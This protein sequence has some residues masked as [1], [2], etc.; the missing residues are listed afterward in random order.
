MKKLFLIAL[1]F[2]MAA[3]MMNCNSK[4]RE[5]SDSSDGVMSGSVVDSV[6]LEWTGYKTTDKAPVSGVF[7]QINVEGINNNGTTPEEVLD[8][9]LVRI[10]ISSLYS[11]D[12]TRD[13]K[14]IDIFFGTM[15]N[16]ELISGEFHANDGNP[17]LSVTM[18]GTT[19][20]IPVTTSL[21]GNIYTLEGDVLLE[22]FGALD[23]VA[24][25]A[26]ACF[27]LHKGADGVSK[28]WDEA[29]FKGAVFF[30]STFE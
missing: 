6:A 15:E 25:L 20:E 8:G 9:A 21:N 30:S 11:G 12:P 1:A 3:A 26:E 23:A 27:D 22:D 17:V 28:T 14:L 4:P 24:A 29:H 19:Q 7:Q 2:T 10:P 13:P 16:T 18:N 5:T